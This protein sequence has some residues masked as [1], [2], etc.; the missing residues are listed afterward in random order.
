MA[1]GTTRVASGAVLVLL[2][3]AVVWFAPAPAFLIAEIGINHNGSVELAKR[4]V[5]L[6]I[7]AGADKVSLN[8]AA[9]SNP[10]LIATLAKRYGSQAV[11]I[12]IDTWTSNLRPVS[13]CFA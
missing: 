8:T 7:E 3:V 4:L 9:L 13:I 10:D 11:I 2:A 6:A 5:D 12:A 1:Q